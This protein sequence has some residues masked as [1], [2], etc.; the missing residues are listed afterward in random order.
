MCARHERRHLLM[1]HLNILQR[2]FRFLECHI[3]GA[4]AVPG[5]PVYAMDA[6]LL[7]SVPDELAHVHAHGDVRVNVQANENLVLTEVRL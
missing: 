7:K 6:P 4:D 5:I 2:G 1:P 3:E